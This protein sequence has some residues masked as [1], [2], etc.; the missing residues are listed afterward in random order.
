M[1]HKY[2]TAFERSRFSQRI[3]EIMD[4]F[5][6]MRVVLILTNFYSLVKVQV[7]VTLYVKKHDVRLSFLLDYIRD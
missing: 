4:G 7:K 6:L 3:V 1:E 2:K 5:V